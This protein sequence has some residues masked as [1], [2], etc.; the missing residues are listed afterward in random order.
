MPNFSSYDSSNVN[1]YSTLGSFLRDVRDAGR[2]ADPK[3]L[4]RLAAAA[5]LNTSISSEGGVLIPDDFAESLWSKIYND[6]E[7]LRRCR[8]F[9]MPRGSYYHIPQV[10]ETTRVD[11]SRFG[12]VSAAWTSEGAAIADSEPRFGLH[13][14]KLRKLGAL[15]Y[16]TDEQL[17]DSDL[18][19]EALEATIAREVSHVFE[20][21]I[22]R[23]DGAKQPQGILNANAKI[24]V[25]AE[26]NQTAATIWGPNIAK[27]FARL[28]GPSQRTAVWLYNVDALP[29]LAALGLEGRYGSADADAVCGPLWNWDGSASSGGWPTLMGRPAIPSEHCSTVGTEGDLI[30]CDLSQVGI[31]AKE[32]ARLSAHVRFEY[33]E[34]CFKFVLRADACS[35]WASAIAPQNGTA[36]QSPFITLA[37]R[38]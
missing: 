20:G 30:L 37:S 2:H 18:S 16:L 35:L 26:T 17:S 10:V 11:G 28:W 4:S 14:L 9:G 24:T 33:A 34:Q 13:T 36:T 15:C 38:A 8:T 31:V 22:V 6:G 19:S 21:A 7:I 29:Y 12:G 5:G 32:K 23:G 1:T 27:M 25:S 3:R